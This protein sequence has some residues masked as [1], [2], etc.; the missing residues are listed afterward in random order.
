V[1]FHA[2]TRREETAVTFSSLV[3]LVS[4]P[5]VVRDREGRASPKE[6][7]HFASSP[8]SLAA[9]TARRAIATNASSHSVRILLVKPEK[10]FTGVVFLD[11]GKPMTYVPPTPHGPNWSN[12]ER[13][14]GACLGSRSQIILHREV[15]TGI[16]TKDADAWALGNFEF[17][18]SC[19]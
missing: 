3:N 11:T 9:R 18:T 1:Q 17:E 15:E 6:Q 5:V 10:G 16:T 2:G 7:N 12:V 13:L 4:V 19:R 14:P 8:P